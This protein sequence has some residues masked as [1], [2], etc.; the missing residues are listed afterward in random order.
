ML[1]RSKIRTAKLIQNIIT[2]NNIDTT[3]KFSYDSFIKFYADKY[4][5]TE[6]IDILQ[7]NFSILDTEKLLDE[8][9]VSKKQAIF[10]KLKSKLDNESL[11]EIN[12]RFFINTGTTYMTPLQLIELQ[13]GCDNING[14]RSIKI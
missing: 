13:R 10:L 6:N 12:A 1:F 9:P 3:K 8:I 5:S 14:I 11:A 7:K 4:F 2:E